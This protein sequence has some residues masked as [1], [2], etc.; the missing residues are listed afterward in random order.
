MCV[1]ECVLVTVLHILA[2]LER[3]SYR[4]QGT[5]SLVACVDGL[6]NGER[7]SSVLVHCLLLG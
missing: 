4:P 2:G 5:E 6:G 3:V 1:S 7:S